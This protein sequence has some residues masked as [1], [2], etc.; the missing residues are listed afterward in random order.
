MWTRCVSVAGMTVSSDVRQKEAE[1]LY[2]QF[3]SMTCTM[4]VNVY[5]SGPTSGFLRT[6]CSI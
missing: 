6:N 4:P 5:S 1:V 2:E 3:Y